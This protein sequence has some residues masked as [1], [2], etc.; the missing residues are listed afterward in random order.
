LNWRVIKFRFQL[1][2][3][4]IYCWLQVATM[5][6]DISLHNL[7]PRWLSTMGSSYAL[8]RRYSLRTTPFDLQQD[9]KFCM[10]VFT[11]KIIALGRS[12]NICF[13]YI[14][15]RGCFEAQLSWFS[16]TVITRVLHSLVLM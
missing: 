1:K 8:Y 12:W 11:D 14:C 15:T 9:W 6:E 4:L 2:N 13:C 7:K 3:M 16:V 5:H 10:S